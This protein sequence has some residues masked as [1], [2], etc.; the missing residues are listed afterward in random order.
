M[1]RSSKRTTLVAL[2]VGIWAVAPLAGQTGAPSLLARRYRLGDSLHFSMSASNQGRTQTVRYSADAD[3]V[4]RKDSLGRFI[5]EF[6]WSH[7]VR[8]GAA[9]S[10]PAGTAAVRQRL[11]LAPEFMLP[12]DVA[13]ADPRLVGPV[14]DLLTFY[15]D[16]WLSAKTA[17]AR[18]GDHARVPANTTN[19]WADGHYVILGEDAIDFEMTLLSI[20]SA[21]GRARLQVRHVPPA[22]TIVRAPASWMQ[23]PLFDTPNNWVEV[24]KTTDTSYVA[25]I[26]RETFDVQIDVRLSDGSILAATMDNPVDVM[27]RVCRDSALASCDAP[28]RY[29]ILRRISLQAR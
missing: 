10:L 4:V 18:A 19:S 17:L 14:L 2:V 29:R 21:V 6:E 13:H 26:G 12:P 3:G 11:T 15:V 16:L 20:D 8:D 9:V 7:L 22:R 28:H 1:T 25:G 27:E 5:E 24:T 23:A